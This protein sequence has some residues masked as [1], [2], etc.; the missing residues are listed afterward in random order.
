MQNDV[1]SF[2]SI[3]RN[4]CSKSQVNFSR[5]RRG[6][7]ESTGDNADELVIMASVPYKQIYLHTYLCVNDPNAMPIARRL[8]HNR[9][10]QSIG[11]NLANNKRLCFL[12][13][14][15]IR[16]IW[17]RKLTDF[18]GVLWNVLLHFDNA[19]AYWV[20]NGR[21]R[22]QKTKIKWVRLVAWVGSL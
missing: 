17:C 20:W 6:E 9:I 4:R 13:A 11:I 1:I 14:Q 12:S 8:M 18:S 5:C 7:C 10:N 16:I 22:V 2:N 19:A 15:L 3:R 21:N